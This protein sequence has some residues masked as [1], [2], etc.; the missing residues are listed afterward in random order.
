M[1]SKERAEQFVKLI[2]MV[3]TT[4]LR[5]SEGIGISLLVLTLEQ[6]RSSHILLSF[7]Y[8]GSFLERGETKASKYP[9]VTFNAVATLPL[10]LPERPLGSCSQFFSCLCCRMKVLVLTLALL[11]CALSMPVDVE[12]DNPRSVVPLVITDYSSVANKNA[13]DAPAEVPKEPA[14]NEEELK[15]EE[16]PAA[17]EDKQETTAAAPSGDEIPIEKAPA[18][19][20]DNQETVSNDPKTADVVLDQE[21]APAEPEAVPEKEEPAQPS[22]AVGSS[23]QDAPLVTLAEEK[24]SDEINPP[25]PV[26][27]NVPKIA[28]K[29]EES[30][31]SEAKPVEEAK[32]EQQ[33]DE[34]KVMAE[35]IKPVE[36]ESPVA[37]ASDPVDEKPLEKGEAPAVEN[38]ANEPQMVEE[39]AKDEAQKSTVTS[40]RKRA[41]DS[42]EDEKKKPTEVTKKEKDDKKA[43]ADDTPVKNI[44]ATPD[45]VKV[46]EA[47]APKIEEPKAEQAASE[48]KPVEIPQPTEDVPEAQPEVPADVES[49]PSAVPEINSDS[50]AKSDQAGENTKVEVG[51]EKKI[52]V[53]KTEEEKV[54]KVQS[55]VQQE[56]KIVSEAVLKDAGTK[57]DEV[58]PVD[59]KKS[60]EAIVVEE[61]KQVT[62]D[63]ISSDPVVEKEEEKA[64]AATN[65]EAVEKKQ[66]PVA[67]E[68]LSEE[69][70]EGTKVAE[71]VSS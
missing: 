32:E 11:G 29:A 63:E 67:D 61:K 5:L 18:P 10:R 42:K 54:E 71:A 30:S 3:Y 14:K 7:G 12:Q 52:E 21:R 57:P 6:D 2:V 34:K 28:E 69:K 16:K 44:D 50:A 59:E 24:V 39:P 62:G 48:V 13:E 15:T 9:V 60:E 17:S 25:A 45:E 49:A 56:T 36:P 43:K 23:S 22:E 41:T 46:S 35:E 37:V 8:I 55:S 64:P 47:E 68:K 26:A 19:S 40:R 31:S 65:I 4:R 38:A 53:P 27:L 51:E 33:A 66:D 20:T 70:G 1:T 58:V